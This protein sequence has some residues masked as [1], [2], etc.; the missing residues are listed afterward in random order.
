MGS[1]NTRMP[2][3]LTP[4]VFLANH[5]L[6]STIKVLSLWTIQ[7]CIFGRMWMTEIWGPGISPSR[8]PAPKSSSY[9][10]LPPPPPCSFSW[11]YD[12][13]VISSH[14][15]SHKSAGTSHWYILTC[16][17]SILSPRLQTFPFLHPIS[18][19]PEYPAPSPPQLLLVFA[20]VPDNYLIVSLNS[21]IT[22]LFPMQFYFNLTLTENICAPGLAGL[23]W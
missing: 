14:N 9:R 15:G 22:S 3:Y 13:T 11:S 7:K 19:F 10:L 1:Q 18:P 4:L 12:M 6:V 2:R 20:D 17:P 23:L 16:F 21:N 8:T 5:S